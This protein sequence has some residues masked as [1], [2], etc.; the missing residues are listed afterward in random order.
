MNVA[1]WPADMCPQCASTQ[2]IGLGD[3]LRLCFGCRHE[4]NP[5]DT[6]GPEEGSE[7]ESRLNALTSSARAGRP[8]GA[9]PRDGARQRE[10]PR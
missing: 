2:G 4:W 7:A 8:V 6:Y 1:T 5:D 3:G 9:A 10:G